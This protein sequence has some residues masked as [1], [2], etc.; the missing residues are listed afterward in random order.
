MHLSHIPKDTIRDDNVHISVL[1]GPFW[2]LR[3]VHCGIYEVDLLHNIKPIN[4]I[5]CDE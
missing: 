4:P 3:Q 5:N 1:S 2:D